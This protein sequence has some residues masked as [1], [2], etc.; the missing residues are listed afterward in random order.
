MLGIPAIG[1]E[2]YNED[3]EG[4]KEEN[5]LPIAVTEFVLCLYGIFPNAV[6]E[7]LERAKQTT[8]PNQRGLAVDGPKTSFVFKE[9]KLLSPVLGAYKDLDILCSCLMNTSKSPMLAS[10]ARKR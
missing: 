7:L 10:T 6:G 5:P 4:D 9:L 2:N 1:E 8:A 3:D